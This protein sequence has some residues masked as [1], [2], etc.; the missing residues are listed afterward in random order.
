MLWAGSALV[1]GSSLLYVGLAD[2]HTP[3]SVYPPCPFKWL[4]G[5]NCPGC[6]GLRMT[7]DLLHGDLAAG[8]ND[9]LFLLV[10][11]PAV[12]AWILVRRQ[13]GG[14]WH[15]KAAVVT[16]VLAVAV[17]TIVRNAP[18]FPLIPTVLSG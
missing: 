15:P 18:G 13:H 17:W 5:W 16:V 9:N 12:A 11:I 6:G 1:L 10:G 14:S 8:I 7:H 2:P 3:G 4:T